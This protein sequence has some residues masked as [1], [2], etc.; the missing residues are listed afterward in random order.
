MRN[1]RIRTIYNN[2]HNFYCKPPFIRSVSYLLAEQRPLYLFLESC[3]PS[4]WSQHLLINLER[5]VYNIVV[6]GILLNLS[7]VIYL[8]IILNTAF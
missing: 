7:F 3:A 6:S 4:R 8:R 5:K 1:R 2:V